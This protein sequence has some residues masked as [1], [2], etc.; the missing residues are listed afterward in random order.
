MPGHESEK[1]VDKFLTLTLGNELGRRDRINQ[2]L[3]FRYAEELAV[4]IINDYVIFSRTRLNASS[5]EN[6][7]KNG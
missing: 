7:I 3:Q 1:L 2:N 4:E 5:F 6:G